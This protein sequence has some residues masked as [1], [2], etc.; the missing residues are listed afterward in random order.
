MSIW[1][2]EMR[3]YVSNL[4]SGKWKKKVR[5]MSDEQV[6]A[7]YLKSVTGK[8]DKREIKK[9]PVIPAK[10]E[11]KVYKQINEQLTISG[12]F[13]PDDYFWEARKK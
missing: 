11:E 6:T 3:D 10:T 9:L 4:Y 12:F 13:E 2:D 5:H 1:I 7:I 8:R